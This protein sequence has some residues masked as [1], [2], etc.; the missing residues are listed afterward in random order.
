MSVIKLTFNDGLQ[1]IS[2]NFILPFL[3][4]M[5]SKPIIWKHRPIEKNNQKTTTTKQQQ[6]VKQEC[7]WQRQCTS[8]QGR[9]LKRRSSYQEES[10]Y[11][12]MS[13]NE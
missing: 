3:F 5:I 4:N 13:P 9:V 2:N 11:I 8:V 10:A 7:E 6:K 1:L 12:L